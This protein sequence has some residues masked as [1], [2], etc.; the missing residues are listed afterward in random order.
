MLAWPVRT[1]A[2]PLSAEGMF[3]AMAP[4][5]ETVPVMAATDPEIGANVPWMTPAAIVMVNV[6]VGFPPTARLPA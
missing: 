1:T 5:A 3:P 2:Q 6:L 4:A